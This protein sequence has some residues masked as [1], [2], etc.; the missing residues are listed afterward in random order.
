[1]SLD[2]HQIAEAIKNP[3]RVFQTPGE[4]LEHDDLSM[5]DKKKILKSWEADQMLLLIAEQENMPGGRATQGVAAE[6]LKL[7]AK[8]K[9]ALKTPRSH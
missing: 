3:D 8:A 4:V 9:E 6:K 5:A 2:H 1:M 7:I